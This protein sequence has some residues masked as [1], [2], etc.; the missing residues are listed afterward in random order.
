MTHDDFELPPLPKEQDIPIIL[1]DIDSTESSSSPD[2]DF[3][4]VGEPPL[5][6]MENN[7]VEPPAKTD[8]KSAGRL[9]HLAREKALAKYEKKSK[10]EVKRSLEYFYERQEAERALARKG[11]AVTQSFGTVFIIAV[12]IHMLLNFSGMYVFLTIFEILLVWTLMRSSAAALKWVKICCVIN[13]VFC[14]SDIVKMYDFGKTVTFLGNPF[15]QAADIILAIF[16]AA[17]GVFLVMSKTVEQ[18]CLHELGLTDEYL[19]ESEL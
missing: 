15:I 19:D 14:I 5:S 10:P 9:K 12:I 17:S 8:Y 4:S 18:Y 16:F 6:D 13:S 3:S 2:K 7:P 11:I 1:G